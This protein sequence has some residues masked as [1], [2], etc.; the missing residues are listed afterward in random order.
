VDG[1]PADSDFV[2]FDQTRFDSSI[3]ELG[4]QQRFFADGYIWLTKYGDVKNVDNAADLEEIL[5]RQGLW[6][7]MKGKFDSGVTLRIV[8]NVADAVPA[9]LTN[10]V[11]GVRQW[12]TSRDIPPMNLI[13]VKRIS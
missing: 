2:R 9:G 13:I 10:K 8:R 6:R 5:Y 1:E 4:I 12:R 7:A 11:N 3:N